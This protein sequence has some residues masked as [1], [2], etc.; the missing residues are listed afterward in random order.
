M[1]ISNSRKYIFVHLHKT[2]GTAITADLERDVEWND[3]VIAGTNRG[4]VLESWYRD[5]FD[6]EMHSSASTIR[7]VVGQ[8][9]WDE[10]YTFTVVRNP[11][12]RILSLYTWIDWL[13][14]SGGW[15][16]SVKRIVSP[17]RGLLAW[18]GVKAYLQCKNFSEFLRH[19]LIQGDAPGALPM[20]DSLCEN[21]KLLVDFV[22]KQ[23]NLDEDLLNIK[24]VIGIPPKPISKSKVSS[25]ALDPNDYYRKQSDLDLVYDH[26]K[27][28]FDLFHYN[29]LLVG[30]L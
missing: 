7:N 25:K 2:A 27:V 20:A 14:S 13:V 28:D 30:Q 5:K 19:P 18:P 22:G 1:I 4:N 23:E 29:R 8:H 6:L 11:Y 15:R 24:D 17:E 3:I 16:L 10:Y 9:I 12:R 21:G 26:Y